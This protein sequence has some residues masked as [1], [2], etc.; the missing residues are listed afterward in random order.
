MW[1]H[2]ELK[3]IKVILFFLIN[4]FMYK[5]AFIETMRGFMCGKEIVGEM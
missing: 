1:L 2:L 5:I 4:T 3:Y